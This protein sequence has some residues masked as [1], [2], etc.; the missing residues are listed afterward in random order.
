MS[1]STREGGKCVFCTFRPS[2]CLTAPFSPANGARQYSQT[3]EFRRTPTINRSRPSELG[4]PAARFMASHRYNNSSVIRSRFRKPGAEFTLNSTEMKS[5]SKRILS[6][7]TTYS[8]F[9]QLLVEEFTKLKY[10]LRPESAQTEYTTWGITS[11]EMLAERLNE[12]EGQIRN[13]IILIEDGKLH[14]E[15]N[16]LFSRFRRAFVVGGVNALRSETKFAFINYVVE[17]KFSQQDKTNQDRLSDLRHPFEWFPATR[18]M[19]RTIHLH[20]GP[21]NSGKTYHALKRLEAANTGIYAGP[22]R[23]LAHEVYSRFNAKGKS[24]MLITGEER[25]IPEDGLMKMSSCTVEMMPLN[26]KVD[27]AVIDEIQMMGDIDRGWAWTQG[28]LG[29]QADEVHLCGE[30]RTIQLVSDICAAIGDKLVIHKYERLSP[31]AAEKRSLEGDL[32][33]LRK[34]DA[35]ILFSRVAIHA[36]KADIEKSTGKRCAVVYGSLPPETRAQ[37]AELFNN[38]DND[39]DFLV[40]SDAVGMG[41]NLSIKRVVFESI[42]K[43]DGMSFRVIQPSEIKQIAGRAG[44]Y[45]TAHQAVNES[46]PQHER[47]IV[48]LAEE[49]DRTNGLVTTLERF[50]LPVVRKAMDLEV[51]PIKTAG[52]QPPAHILFRYASYFPKGTAFSYITRRLWDMCKLGDLFHMCRLKEQVDIADLL[53]PYDLSTMDRIT[54]MAAP[55][56]LREPGFGKIVQEFAE[57]V[58]TQSGGELLDLKTLNLELLDLDKDT[59]VLGSKAYLKSAESLHKALTLYLWLSYRFAGVFR[60]QALAFHVKGLVEAKIDECLAEVQFDSAKKKHFNYLRKK[61]LELEMAEQE[62]QRQAQDGLGLEE[63]VEIEDESRES[64]SLENEFS[65]E[66]ADGLLNEASPA[67]EAGV[68][69]PPK[70]LVKSE[71]IN[72]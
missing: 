37:Q 12:Y 15:T 11:R 28:F 7:S 29:V 34:G 2:A 67:S 44:R 25:R 10:S 23:L 4:P 50:D 58:A 48:P 55:V 57:C 13:S 8:V 18:A 59:Y 72:P 42:S 53:E 39:Y 32:T 62:Q 52:I 68:P 30:L 6:K 56:A 22:L 21:T 17:F 36:M 20:V 5:G 54:F 70:E 60:S 9:G 65:E 3:V 19:H 51:E 66:E 71:T 31:L 26:K 69:I 61:A 46:S 38:P 14:K 64:S 35:V 63:D 40:A 24:C 49:A 16:P 43:H 41:L 1:F 47:T 33:K 27:V 45:K